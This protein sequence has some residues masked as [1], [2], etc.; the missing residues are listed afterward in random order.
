MEI[1]GNSILNFPLDNN[2]HTKLHICNFTINEDREFVIGIDDFP[3][4][5]TEELVYGNNVLHIDYLLC[6][7]ENNEKF[8]LYDC[9]IIPLQCPKTKEVK[10]IWKRYLFGY[11]IVNEENE[12]V[13][14]AEYVVQT[15][16]K[17][18]PFHMFVG[19][20]DFDILSGNVHISTDWHTEM[21]KID[22]VK[23]GVTT[24][25]PLSISNIEKIVLRLIE[26]YSLQTGFFPRIQKRKMATED[27]KEFYYWE[28]FAAYGKT[29]IGNIRLEYALD[30]EKEQDYSCVYEKWW[31]LREKEVATFN[32]FSYIT[33]DNSPII[34][35]PVATCIQ[36]L[37]GY[38]RIHHTEDLFKFSESIK[39]QIK[40]ET[41][42]MFENSS[43]LRIIC[44]EN[45][46]DFEGIKDSI[47]R[48]IGH[49]NEYSLKEILLYAIEQCDM[50][51][52]LFEYERTTKVDEK[53]NLLDVFLNKSAG[54]RN[55]LSH[56]V[57]Q[58]N[59]F[60]NEEITLATKKLK[61]LFRLTLL[62]DIGVE[63]SESSLDKV[64]NSI[65]KWYKNNNLI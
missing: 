52:K 50:T 2:G 58:K 6:V 30:M 13:C 11:H 26:I 3:I 17:K 22:G 64:I 39:K 9:I 1:H 61:L 25:K 7:D 34:E 5:T 51:K 19:R 59:K 62:N 8:T 4:E 41:K 31:N 56:L 60:V 33:T 46:I 44:K 57:E 24:E 37:E 53:K 38:F 43:S 28:E 35:V 21:F 63:I 32:L 54:H 42:Q 45:S 65:N 23:I 47:F 18:Y 40:K 20:T 49:I 16:E 36:C 48:S 10:V 15:D 12:K 14:C 27:N 29:A 55:W